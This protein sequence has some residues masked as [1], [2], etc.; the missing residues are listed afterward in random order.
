MPILSKIEVPLF[1]EFSVSSRV[2]KQNKIINKNKKKGKKRMI[3]TFFFDDEKI[4]DKKGG[5][6]PAHIR[7][8]LNNRRSILNFP[9]L[10]L[11]LTKLT[12]TKKHRRE[13]KNRQRLIPFLLIYKTCK[14]AEP[15]NGT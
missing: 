1:H 7:L 4:R 13:A 10:T 3:T 9:K 6:L 2:S 8:N 12:K 5:K 14:S 11:K 15:F